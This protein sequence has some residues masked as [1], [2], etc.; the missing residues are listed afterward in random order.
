[1]ISF[2]KHNFTINGLDN[3]GV[4]SQWRVGSCI[5]P[6]G[7]HLTDGFAMDGLDNLG[8][9]SQRRVGAC[10][11]LIGVRLTGVLTEDSTVMIFLTNTTSQSMDWTI[12]VCS[13]N[14]GWWHA[15]IP[16]VSA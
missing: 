11:N 9:F 6:I 16:S 8:A 14:G 13:L 2:N 5:N 3:L 7:V 15:L 10:I 4:F 1:M 12:W